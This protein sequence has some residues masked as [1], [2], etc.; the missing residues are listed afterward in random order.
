LDSIFFKKINRHKGKLIGV[1]IVK[2]LSFIN[3][4][5]EFINM[6]DLGCDRPYAILMLLS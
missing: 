3:N 5:D 1:P 4:K 2:M 6:G